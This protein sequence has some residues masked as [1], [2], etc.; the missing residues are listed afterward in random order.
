MVFFY[1]FSWFFLV[2]QKGYSCR[3]WF[4]TGFIVFCFVLFSSFFF[5]V[6]YIGVF[7]MVLI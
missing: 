1:Y 7:L 6:L 3:L 4:S 5:M 2:S